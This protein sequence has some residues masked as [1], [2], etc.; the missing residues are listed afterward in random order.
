VRK[1]REGGIDAYQVRRVIQVKRE[2]TVTVEFVEVSQR[3]K[4]RLK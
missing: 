1:P 3:C 4:K 2:G